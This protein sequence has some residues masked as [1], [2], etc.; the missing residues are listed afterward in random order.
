MGSLQRDNGGTESVKDDYGKYS[1]VIIGPSHRFL[2]GI[3]YFTFRLSNALA[4][5]AN[6]SVVLFRNMLPKHLFPGWKRVGKG[7]SQY[8]FREDIQI[9]EILDWYNPVTWAQGSKVAGKG[10]VIIFQW[11][12]SSVAHMYLAI[13]ILNIG[14]KPIIIEFH[15]IVDPFESGFILLR[16]YSRITGTLIRKLS[17]GYVVHSDADRI[18][19][20][21]HYGIDKTKVRV[22]PMGIFDQYKILEKNDA[23]K[24]L[25][26]QES[27]VILFFGLLRPY[28]GVKFLIEAFEQLPFELVNVTRLLIVGESWEDQETYDRVNISP[29]ISNITFINRYVGDAEIPYFFS[30]ADILV[31]PY[32]RA[33][34]SAVAHIGMAYGIPIVAS[35][36]GG[37]EE[38][39]GKYKGTRFVKPENMIELAKA[40]ELTLLNRE[41]YDPPEELRWER[42]AEHWISLIDDVAPKR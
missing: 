32:T 35:R 13:A 20:S 28:K 1:V 3:S 8:C 22:I 24:H 5:Y 15:E 6:V 4:D 36:V 38:G 39:L 12:T 2:S 14:R 30:A 23:K 37:L 10:D 7:L 16:L 40:L 31:I 41:E 21:S 26:I 25:E 33:S 17:K 27:N 18:L 11:W 29:R 42:I 19:I 34:Q 9:R